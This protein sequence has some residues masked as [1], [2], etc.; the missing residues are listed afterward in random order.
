MIAEEQHLDTSKIVAMDVEYGGGRTVPRVAVT[1][2]DEQV[3]YYSDFC[4]RYED[5]IETKLTQVIEDLQ[6]INREDCHDTDDYSDP[7]L[8]CSSDSAAEEAEQKNSDQDDGDV[9][10]DFKVKSRPVMSKAAKLDR[11]LQKKRFNED[12][13]AMQAHDTSPFVKRQSQVQSINFNLNTDC[14]N[15]VFELDD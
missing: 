8:E 7:S 6:P 11:Y 1:G 2:F 12:E 10:P 4:L 14:V 15:G 13:Q 5:W 3:L 9:C